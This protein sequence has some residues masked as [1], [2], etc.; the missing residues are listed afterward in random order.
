MV[1]LSLSSLNVCCDMCLTLD[2]ETFMTAAQTATHN[3]IIFQFFRDSDLIIGTGSYISLS[4][5][6][7]HL[8]TKIRSSQRLPLPLPLLLPYNHRPLPQRH[9]THHQPAKRHPT[10]GRNTK[11][12]PHK[13]GPRNRKLTKS[14]F[15]FC[16]VTQERCR[17]SADHGKVECRV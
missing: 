7:D 11:S 4:H 1:R 9:P 15:G 6:Q 3:F 17:G 14:S 8:L 2:F 16:P 12:K 5:T 10:N 13:Q